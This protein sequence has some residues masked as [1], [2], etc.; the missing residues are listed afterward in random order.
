M[1]NTYQCQSILK[2]RDVRECSIPTRYKQW[3]GKRVVLRCKANGVRPKTFIWKLNN[4][5]VST[6]QTYIFTLNNDTTGTYVCQVAH[7]DGDIV[8]SSKCEVECY[9]AT[10]LCKTKNESLDTMKEKINGICDTKRNETS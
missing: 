2:L 4:I 1:K 8:T 6:A 7:D 5:K 3:L 9:L 10:D